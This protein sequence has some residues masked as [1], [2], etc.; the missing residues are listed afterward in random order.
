MSTQQLSDPRAAMTASI[1]PLHNDKRVLGC[2]DHRKPDRTM[3]ATE[4]RDR[5]KKKHC[6][7]I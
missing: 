2:D 4:I 7:G 6:S 3:I 5:K 1:L